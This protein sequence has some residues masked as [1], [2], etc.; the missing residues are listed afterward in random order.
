M[1]LRFII[2][3]STA[4]ANIVFLSLHM[5][6][7]FFYIAFL[8][9]PYEVLSQNAFSFSSGIS[10]DM[11]NHVKFQQIPL[12]VEWQSGRSEKHKLIFRGDVGF[13]I[14]N[15]NYDSAYTIE[16][17]LPPAIAVQKNIEDYW[18]TISM[19]VRYLIKTK[20][21]DARF[22]VDFFPLGFSQQK[23]KIH[24]KSYDKADYNIINPDVGLNRAGFVL[25]LG[26]GYYT[27][28]LVIQIHFQTPPAVSE[29]RYALSYHLNAPLLFTVGYLLKYPKNKRQ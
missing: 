20:S 27:K 6:K 25:S 5:S 13:P 19:G 1:P 29:K 17:S 23:F 22:I 4:F 24:Y 18:Y 7:L 11:N 15:R 8:L 2:F 14:P 12:S 28:N 21:K 9:M 3:G 16:N 10:L 26:A